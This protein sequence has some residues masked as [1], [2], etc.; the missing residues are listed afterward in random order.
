M[1]VVTSVPA[2]AINASAADTALVKKVY[3]VEQWIK[4]N[5]LSADATADYAGINSY[6]DA[7][8]DKEVNGRTTDLPSGKNS[9]LP[10]INTLD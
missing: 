10:G 7:V 1:M 4:N 3:D 6:F 2:F 9:W 8:V 5:A